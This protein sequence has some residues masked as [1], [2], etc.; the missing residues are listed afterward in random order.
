MSLIHQSL[1]FLSATVVAV[2]VFKKLGLGSVLGYLSAGIVIGPWVLGLVS[3]V[4][5]ILHFAEFGVV[6]LLFV[7]GLELQPSR[8]W[9][10]RKNVFGLGSVQVIGSGVVLAGISLLLGQSV[11]AAV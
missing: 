4:D 5:S 3:D 1:V 7:I 11:S 2:P 9:A 10:L 8:L 6:L